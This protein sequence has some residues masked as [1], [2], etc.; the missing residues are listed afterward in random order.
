LLHPSTNSSR[1]V[2]DNFYRN[3]K[4]ATF[5]WNEDSAANEDDDENSGDNGVATTKLEPRYSSSTVNTVNLLDERVIPYDLIIRL[6]ETICYQNEAYIPYSA[7]ILVF[8]PGISDI[9]RLHDLLVD[10][11]IFGNSDAFQIH[12]L[13]STISTENQG[14]VFELPPVGVRK[15]VIGEY[16]FNIAN[17]IHLTL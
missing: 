2:T 12:P 13:H 8:M 14:A 7:A 3:G 5:E 6:M 15:I 11:D 16:A 9:R 4:H 17:L 10:H 1:Q